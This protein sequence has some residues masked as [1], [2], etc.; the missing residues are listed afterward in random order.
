LWQ[1]F[2]FTPLWKQLKLAKTDGGQTNYNFDVLGNLIS[3]TLPGGTLIE[4]VVD[5]R[6]RRIGKKVNGTLERGW[7]YIDSLS[8]VAE[9]DGTG[10]VVSRFVYGSRGNT[11]DFI[12]KGGNTY[13]VISDHLGSPR[14]VIDT[15]TGTVIQT[16]DFDEWGNVIADTNPEFQPF[17]FAGGLYD[18]DTKLVRFGARDY[19]AEIGRWTSKD[20]IQF[21]GGGLNLYGYVDGVGKPL[22]EANLYGYTFNDPINFLDPTGKAGIGSAFGEAVG[23]IFSASGP[24]G[25]TCGLA[26][27]VACGVAVAPFTGLGS[28]VAGGACGVAGEAFGSQFDSPSAG[29]AGMGSELPFKSKLSS[30]ELLD[31]LR[32]TERFSIK[33][34]PEGGFSIQ[35]D[36][37]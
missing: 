34:P 3:V 17:G 19:D 18:T 24:I 28:I 36:N 21:R 9:L 31:L 26:A 33:P 10:A 14:L 13:R 30:K 5:G 15:A 22:I 25:L 2:H 11:P 35:S 12:V 29:T 6:N 37:N 20:P 7:L 16:M 8:P 23:G 4:Y 27:G 1:F 32:E